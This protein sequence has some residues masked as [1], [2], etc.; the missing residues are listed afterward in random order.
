M[1]II[2]ALNGENKFRGFRS[3]TNY[4]NAVEEFLRLVR[5]R[6]VAEQIAAKKTQK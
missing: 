6:M 3:D 2:P 1:L 4:E 5:E